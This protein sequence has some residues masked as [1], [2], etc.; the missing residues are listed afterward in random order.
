MRKHGAHNDD[1]DGNHHCFDSG[2]GKMLVNNNSRGETGDG[3]SGLRRHVVQSLV[4]I[5]HQQHAER[6]KHGIHDANGQQDIND[7]LR[8][9]HSQRSRNRAKTNPPPK[10]S[11]AEARAISIIGRRWKPSE[12]NI[13]ITVTSAPAVSRPTRRSMGS[14]R[15]V[16]I[17]SGTR[18]NIRTLAARSQ[19]FTPWL[20]G[21]A[22]SGGQYWVLLGESPSLVLPSQCSTQ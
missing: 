15:K 7:D 19:G 10:A 14:P 17:P 13:R 20:R 18:A 21:S 1:D 5:F 11:S 3:N 16:T 9:A 6:T 22:L 2:G 4:E 12:S 8:L